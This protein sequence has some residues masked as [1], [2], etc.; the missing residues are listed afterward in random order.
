[1]KHMELDA[2]RV[3][4][5]VLSQDVTN[6]QTHSFVQM[7]ALQV[8]KEQI[9]CQVDLTIKLL[10]YR[11]KILLFYILKVICNIYNM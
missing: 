11:F 7:F 1:M 6:F 5:S 4:L 10:C 3:P 2:G 9:A 8:I